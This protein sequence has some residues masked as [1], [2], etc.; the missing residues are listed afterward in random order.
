MTH[1]M[2]VLR[3]LRLCCVALLL[4]VQAAW[5]HAQTPVLLRCDSSQ[6]PL[7]KARVALS[8]S[9]TRSLDAAEQWVVNDNNIPA[10][11]LQARRIDALRLLPQAQL[12]KE[13]VICVDVSNS[14]T[15]LNRG[16]VLRSA[17]DALTEVLLP[18]GSRVAIV[19]FDN[20]AHIG[21]DLTTDP[22]QIQS[23][24]SRMFSG[25]SSS[26]VN[27]LSQ[28]LTGAFSVLTKGVESAAVVV[29]TDGEDSFA[30][31]D[32]IT[33]ARN[34]H[35]SLSFLG[36][37]SLNLYAHEQCA[38]STGGVVV[39]SFCNEL[40]VGHAARALAAAICGRNVFDLLWTSPATNDAQHTIR[41]RLL[42]DSTTW[43]FQART[44]VRRLA[45][46]DIPPHLSFGVVPTSAPAST[47]L[48]LSA[49][50][51]SFVVDSIRMDDPSTGFSIRGEYPLRVDSSTT[52]NVPLRYA[53]RDTNF[54]WTQLR[55]FVRN[56][57]TRIVSLS[58]GKATAAIKKPTIRMLEPAPGS[59]LF[60]DSYALISWEGSEPGD[61]HRIDISTDGGKTWQVSADSVRGSGYLWHTPMNAAADVRLRVSHLGYAPKA[62]GVVQQCTIAAPLRIRDARSFLRSMEM[63]P[64]VVG[65]RKDKIFD[66]VFTN[67]SNAAV[68]IDG[69]ELSGENAN[70]FVLCADQPPITIEPGRT[71]SLELSFMPRSAGVRSARVNLQTSIGFISAPISGV[72][73]EPRMNVQSTPV[74]FGPVII[75]ESLSMELD[76]YF[77]K[78]T[79]KA[80]EIRWIELRGPDTSQFA[81]TVPS[82]RTTSVTDYPVSASV[83]F[84]ARR[85]QRTSAQVFVHTNADD[86]PLVLQLVASGVDYQRDLTMFR[87]VVA[88]TAATVKAGAVAVGSVNLLGVHAA[89]GITDNIMMHAGAVLPVPLNK[90]TYALGSVGLKGAWNLGS[91]LRA[92]IGYQFAHSVSDNARTDS[93]EST[94]STHIPYAVLSY[95]DDQSR[96]SLCTGY[97]MSGHITAAV[98]AG[99]SSS[100][101][102]AVLSAELRVANKWKLVTELV[103]AESLN[104]LPLLITARYLGPSYAIDAGL[105]YAGAAQIGSAISFPFVPMIAGTW[106]W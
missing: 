89:A 55:V 65:S 51:A 18:A 100:S 16:A 6:F 11:L 36:L 2:S 32:L 102:F 80:P 56:G 27:A 59:A 58:A 88:P 61:A 21:C 23:G 45:R 33:A 73:V 15:E 24:M 85:P 48:S 68:R 47:Y 54:V 78:N 25:R 66:N 83:T 106:V 22:A 92:G 75:G 77:T 13:V 14:I 52:V 74:D 79:S 10:P 60:A 37:G 90:Q 96:V 53:P 17:V 7:M 49:E 29:I 71:H 1:S 98:P 20:N 44:P 30:T 91:K 105:G 5:I 40:S 76:R 4:A 67:A 95:G 104:A 57:G 34:A 28:S 87:G 9:S 26:V 69:I 39:R 19:F 99:F 81:F 50:N 46:L 62:G 8:G 42:S 3:N 93:V 72:A 84:N 86:S 103:G 64:T 31:T 63:N 94:I 82:V 70:E 38:D 43:E 97:A 35:A 12:P 41:I 101:V